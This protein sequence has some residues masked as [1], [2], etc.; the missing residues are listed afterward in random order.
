MDDKEHLK[1]QSLLDITDE[2]AD[3]VMCIE[4]AEHIESQFTEGMTWENY[5]E[6]HVDHRLPITSFNCG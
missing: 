3:L 1:Q 4:V 5:G 2:K 6:W